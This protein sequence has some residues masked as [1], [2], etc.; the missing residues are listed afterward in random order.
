MVFLLFIVTFLRKQYSLILDDL[1]KILKKPRSL[2][3]YA[4]ALAAVREFQNPAAFTEIPEY[5]AVNHI[6]YQVMRMGDTPDTI[7]YVAIEGQGQGSTKKLDE[8]ER[9]RIQPYLDVLKK[10]QDMEAAFA[11]GLALAT[12]SPVEKEIAKEY[13]LRIRKI[14]IEILQM[15]P[16]EIAIN[17]ID[18]LLGSVRNP[19]E[20]NLL[21]LVKSEYLRG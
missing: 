5:A 11:A 21:R 17:K 19:K 4:D 6:M 14:G 20:Q 2:K 16:T 9:R 7:R 13:I 10:S 18:D 1:R 8:H 12:F 3:Q 15:L